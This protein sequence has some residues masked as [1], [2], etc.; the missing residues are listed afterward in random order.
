[1]TA[2]RPDE[3]I[4]PGCRLGHAVVVKDQTG[5]T[6]DDA[7]ALA[8]AGAA[9]GVVVLAEEQSAGRGRFERRWL[10]DPG[11]N[12][13]FSII[14]RPRTL[15]RPGLITLAAGVGLCAAV[16][17]AGVNVKIK[18]PN[19][20][21]AAGKKLAGILCEAGSGKDGDFVVLGIGLNV[22]QTVFA[23]ELAATSVAAEL[24]RPVERAPLFRRALAEL[25][26]ALGLAESEP[27]HL[28]GE[29][30]DR[31][32]CKGR[33]VRAETTAGTITG[34][35]VGVRDDGAL[36]VRVDSGAELAVIAGDVTIDD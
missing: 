10:S 35:A 23:P 27:D 25:E 22:N 12:L 14:L 19:D 3:L 33:R 34:E 21:R 4:R 2:L 18:W 26:S 30:L 16:R 1:M 15:E 17:S 9:E 8:E 24:G 31:A 11:A 29:W 6:N 32:E 5:S 28:L 20:L 36:L 7:R 13:L